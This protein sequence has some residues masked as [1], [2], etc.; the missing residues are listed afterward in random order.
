MQQVQVIA[1]SLGRTVDK[2]ENRCRIL[3][4]CLARRIEGGGRNQESGGCQTTLHICKQDARSGQCRDNTSAVT[5]RPL[6]TPTDPLNTGMDD[7]WVDEERIHKNENAKNCILRR[8][9]ACNPWKQTGRQRLDTRSTG[10]APMQEGFISS[11]CRVKG[12]AALY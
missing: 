9:K 7:A 5:H 1:K 3:L 10:R 6:Q 12:E 8:M 2:T 11:I 4:A